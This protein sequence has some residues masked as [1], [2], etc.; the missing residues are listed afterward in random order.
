MVLVQSPYICTQDDPRRSHIDNRLHGL[1]VIERFGW[2][3]GIK[4]GVPATSTSA[5]SG[6][7]YL[8][9]PSLHNACYGILAKALFSV[10][11]SP[12]CNFC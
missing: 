7:N 5:C 4:C 10:F 11:A 8:F 12:L 6:F 9:K 1:L 2:S 3:T